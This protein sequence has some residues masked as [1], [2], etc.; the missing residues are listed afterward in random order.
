MVA[1]VL[2][3][4]NTQNE[5]DIVF[6]SKNHTFLMKM[7]SPPDMSSDEEDLAFDAAMKVSLS[8]ERYSSMYEEARKR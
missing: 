1:K 6:S 7:A 3:L 8:S 2:N 5:H 4:E